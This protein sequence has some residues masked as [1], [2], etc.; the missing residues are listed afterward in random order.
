MIAIS[1]DLFTRLV[2]QYKISIQ[3][4]SQAKLYMYSYIIVLKYIQ[5]KR[6]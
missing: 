2:K 4:N 5:D 1:I 6:M 3:T